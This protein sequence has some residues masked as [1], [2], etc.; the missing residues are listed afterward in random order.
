MK[1]LEQ[2]IFAFRMRKQKNHGNV[3]CYNL[4]I[5]HNSRFQML[6]LNYQFINEY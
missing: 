3:W 6:I 4:D 2:L 5:D 1:K